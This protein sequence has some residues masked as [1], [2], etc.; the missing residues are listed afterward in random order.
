[1]MRLYL[2]YLSLLAIFIY[3]QFYCDHPRRDIFSTTLHRG[4]VI[5]ITTPKQHYRAIMVVLSSDDMEIF[6]ICRKVWQAYLSKEPSIRV[7]LLY[8]QG[9][10]FTRQPYDLVYDDIPETAYPNPGMI[11][12]TLRAMSEIL[13]KFTFDFFIRTNIS[14]FWDFAALLR[15]LDLLPK[16]LCYS[17]DGRYENGKFAGGFQDYYLSGTDTIVNMN[18]VESFVKHTGTMNYWTKFLTSHEDQAMGL[19][20]NGYLGAEFRQSRIHR[21]EH[22]TASKPDIRREIMQ[23]RRIGADHYRVKHFNMTNR[24]VV[25]TLI[26]SEL[27]RSIYH[28]QI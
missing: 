26:Y 28:V 2:R 15:H 24:L 14:T 22:L 10:S 12:K 27:L 11:L 6:R 16:R 20:F 7:F 19:F 25:D 9:T 1:M 5:N 21:M 3:L 18:M 13:D 8:G 17:G 4:E 23:G